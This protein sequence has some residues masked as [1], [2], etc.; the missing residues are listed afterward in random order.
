MHLFQFAHDYADMDNHY[1]SDISKLSEAHEDV[2][3]DMFLEEVY[4]KKSQ[5]ENEPWLKAVSGKSNWIFN[6]KEMRDHVLE[7]AGVP[8]K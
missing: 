7:A 6:S 1:E 2:R 3:E 4:G 5:M 8:K